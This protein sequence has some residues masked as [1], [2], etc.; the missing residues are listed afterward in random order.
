[1][2][3]FRHRDSTSS[4]STRPATTWR[5][6]SPAGTSHR[7]VV[8]L[9]TVIPSAARDD[10]VRPLT[11]APVNRRRAQPECRHGH[12]TRPRHRRTGKPAGGGQ[13]QR[14]D[15]RA[16]AHAGAARRDDGSV[17][18]TPAAPMR[19]RSASGGS[20]V[21][22]RPDQLRVRQV[23]A[24]G[25]VSAPQAGSGLRLGAC[26]PARGSHIH[27]LRLLPAEDTSH[28]GEITDDSRGHR[29]RGKSGGRPRD[30]PRLQRSTL[31]TPS[32]QTPIEHG[33]SAVP[34]ARNIHQTLAALRLAP[35]PS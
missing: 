11:V 9:P 25:D 27:D 1:M 13:V 7:R 23:P 8:R 17:G 4:T 2:C 20:S 3:P 12:P 34:K 5:P 6:S 15:E 33:D 10:S 26:E 28:R 14:V 21:P 22:V 32:R 30:L 16:G 18:S 19:R 29:A 31:G 24:S 35:E